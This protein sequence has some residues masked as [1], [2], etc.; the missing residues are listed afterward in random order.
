MIIN[1][2]QTVLSVIIFYQG[3][4]G[5]VYF[6]FAF[7]IAL[8][9]FLIYESCTK[10]RSDAGNRTRAAWVKTRNPNH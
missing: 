1:S 5:F 8:Y 7:L 10:S 9:T 2:F 3:Y 4:A 6:P